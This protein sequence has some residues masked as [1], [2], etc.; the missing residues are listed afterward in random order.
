MAKLKPRYFDY[1]EGLTLND[2]LIQAGG[3]TGSAS[4]KVE[5][6]RMII[7]EKFDDNDLR[8]LKYL[9]LKSHRKIMNNPKILN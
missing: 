1:F 7:A 9:I 5:I 8:K 3:L 2:L 4:K 6:A